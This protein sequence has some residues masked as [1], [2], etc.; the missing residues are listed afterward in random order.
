[1]QKFRL[2]HDY[3]HSKNI[4]QKNNVFRPGKSNIELLKLTHC[5]DYINNFCNNQLDNKAQRRMGLPWSPALKNRTLIAPNGTLLTASIALKQGIACHLAGGTHHAHFDFGSGFCIFNDLVFAAKAILARGDA[6]RI[7]IFDC[8]VHQGDGTASL[9][10]NEDGIFTCSIHCQKNFPYRKVAS[11]LDIGLDKETDDNTYLTILE[12]TLETCIEKSQADLILYDAGV[13]IFTHDPLG[14]LH[15]SED[16][17]RERDN[18]V[19]SKAKQLN[20]PIATVIGG[21]YDVDE[22]ALAK[23]H[24]IVIE[25]AAKIFS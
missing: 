12:K 15:I 6:K 22:R 19:L 7:L 4:A 21:G 20:I 10:R 14:L 23:R 2:L 9:C 8:D 1:M 13:D 5:Q 25:L 3:L 18:L 24:A 16:G 17:I 11:D